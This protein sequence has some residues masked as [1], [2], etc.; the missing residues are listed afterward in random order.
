MSSQYISYMK[1]ASF[2]LCIRLAGLQVSFGCRHLQFTNTVIMS[3]TTCMQRAINGKPE[4]HRSGLP[5]L[6][7]TSCSA[8]TC[9]W[10]LKKFGSDSYK[11][12][13]PRIIPFV[14]VHQDSATVR[15]HMLSPT[16]FSCHIALWWSVW[17]ICPYATLGDSLQIWTGLLRLIRKLW[18]S[19]SPLW[20][21]AVMGTFY[22][23]L[24]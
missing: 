5:T 12:E 8:A 14:S 10:K 7:S 11:R 1:L 22:K 18:V 4:A 2:N 17:T 20:L 15:K 9:A 16:V 19:L 21:I 3:S 24:V 13:M 23:V 6:A